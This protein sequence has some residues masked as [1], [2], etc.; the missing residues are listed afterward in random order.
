MTSLNFGIPAPKGFNPIS[1]DIL[2]QSLVMRFEHTVHQFPDNLAVKDDIQTL[3]YSTLNSHVN[4]VAQEI[5]KLIGRGDAPI[6]FLLD[7]NVYGIIARF[8]ILKSGRP[9]LGIHPSNPA[10]QIRMILNDSGAQIL[11]TSKDKFSLINEI[12]LQTDQIF[13]LY[14]EELQGN[15]PNENPGIYVEPDYPASLI[16]T[17]GSTGK[18]K[19]IVSSHIS[20]T[21]SIFYLTNNLHF[22]P[23][24]RISLLTSLSVA[25]GNPS[26]DGALMNGGL[27][28]LFDL[29]KH[30][31]QKA[32][33]WIAS[34]ELTIFRSTPSMLRSVFGQ[35]P[36]DLIFPNLRI[37]TLGGEPVT[38]EDVELF[39]AHTNENCILINNFAA[40]ESLSMAHYPVSHKTQLTGNFLPAGFPAPD[41]EIFLMNE[42]GKP[43]EQ[44]EEGEIVAR[45]RYM[46][47]GY[48]KQPELTAKLFHT[49]PNDP[50]LKTYYSG[51]LGRWRE[52]GALESLGRIDNKVK[53]RGFSVQLDALDHLLQKLDGIKEAASAA[54]KS[55]NGTKR[56]AAYLVQDGNKN[57]SVTE[58][59]DQISAQLPEY[60]IPS[61]FIWLDALPRTVT[62]KI[63]RKGLPY[64]SS[65]RPNLNNQYLEPRNEIEDVLAKIWCKILELE[66]VG[67]EDNFFELGGDSLSALDMTIEV[68][69]VLRHTISPS[70][71]K[72]PTIVHLVQTL[73][74]EDLHQHKG[75]A[76]S[77]QENVVPTRNK[78]SPERANKKKKFN[79][80]QKLTS[81][82]FWF[83]RVILTTPLV[84]KRNLLNKS[85]IDGN[86]WLTKWINQPFVAHGIYQAKYELFCKLIA[87]LDGCNVDPDKAFRANIFGNILQLVHTHF[88]EDSLTLLIDKLRNS[89]FKYLNSLADLM[90]NSP[91]SELDKSFSISGLE[92]FEKAF[93]RSRGVIILT[94]HST[95][96]SFAISALPRRLG[97]ELIPT[98]STR[99]GVKKD[100]TWQSYRSRNIPIVKRSGLNAGEAYQNQLLLKQGK[101]VQFVSDGSFDDKSDSHRVIIAGRQYFITPGFAKIALNTGATIIPQFTTTRENGQI[102]TTFMPPLIAAEGDRDLQVESLVNQYADFINS[103]WITAPE[104]LGWKRIQRHFSLDESE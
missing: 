49:D 59:R 19:A 33:E 63:N 45:S 42:E 20:S 62:G 18:P 93:N 8:G 17:S 97:I 26:I 70:F 80:M 14:I 79:L 99:I 46:S 28:C 16:Y 34:E 71:F 98:V 65:N 48:W 31:P 57:L 10:D 68:E 15:S 55:S 102:H 103:S 83:D 23:S 87:S 61:A 73:E 21:H 94:Y 75:D 82:G 5:I 44:G 35:A 9:F 66:K 27:L 77:L 92:I 41:M 38:I 50:T 91:I 76:K 30:G 86:S 60:M 36:K 101:I 2:K 90:E 64:P 39:K 43:V 58:L 100:P 96:N 104:S 56:I 67:V 72:K 52:D 51:D 47:S 12:I 89:E 78:Y 81:K 37:M 95:I 54:Y 13:V 11:I 25:A 69:S 88:M 3:S 4:R 7:H 53:I 29:K 40:S 85:Y 1:K 32:L 22:C 74:Q 6:T 84:F 24:D